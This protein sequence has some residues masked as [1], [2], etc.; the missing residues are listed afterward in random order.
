MWWDY[1][2][3]PKL[4]S[5]DGSGW[6]ELD[7]AALLGEVF[8]LGNWKNYNELEENLSM[9]ELIQTLKS[10]QKKDTDNKRFLAAMQGVDLDV[11]EDKKEGPT[12]EDVRRRALGIEADESDIV[13]LQG[14]LAAE[15]GFGLGA[16]L[17]YSKE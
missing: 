9:P 8:L 5:G 4:S 11:D 14:P 6:S 3:R 10:A 16:G 2:G 1:D 17:G 13:S 12:F 15:A 7:L